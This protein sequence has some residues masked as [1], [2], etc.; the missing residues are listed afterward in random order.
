MTYL[1]GEVTVVHDWT[2]IDFNNFVYSA[3]RFNGVL[4][5]ATLVING[6]SVTKVVGITIDSVIDENTTS[7]DEDLILLGNPKPVF[8]GTFDGGV[9]NTF[10]D[11]KYSFLFDAPLN[12]FMECP[13]SGGGAASPLNLTTSGTISVWVKPEGIL[14]ADQNIIDRA[15]GGGGTITAGYIIMWDPHFADDLWGF[16]LRLDGAG[17]VRIRSTVQAIAGEWRHIVGTFDSVTGEANLFIDGILE[18]TSGPAHIGDFIVTPGGGTTM[19]IGCRHPT[20]SGEFNGN[21]DAISIWDKALSQEEIE[22]VFNGG[23]P[24]NLNTHSAVSNGISWWRMGENATWD[25]T[26]WTVEDE[27]GG[28]NAISDGMGYSTRVLDVPNI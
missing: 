3:F 16:W 25:G 27:W 6:A 15:S 18:T 4:G 1:T 10:M 26:N 12:H 17:I 2:R 20:P 8:P 22:E 14:A 7:I 19:V 9:L 24:G 11:S 28:I 5:G 13:T 23:S 21:V